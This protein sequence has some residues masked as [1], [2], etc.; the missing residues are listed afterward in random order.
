MGRAAFILAGALLLGGVASAESLGEWAGA[1][2]QRVDGPALPPDIATA[3]GQI[4]AQAANRPSAT[5]DWVI[6][7]TPQTAPKKRKKRRRR[8]RRRRATQ[9]RDV[10]VLATTSSAPPGKR[11]AK[12]GLL[13]LIRPTGGGAAIQAQRPVPLP[14]D[15]RWRWVTATDVDG[16]GHGDTILE[17][18]Q[19]SR[20]FTRRG[21]VVARTRPPALAMI[22][23]AS[24]TVTG[25]GKRVVEPKTAC[26]FP[27][28][29]L[30]SKALIVQRRETTTI[31]GVQRQIDA[32]ELF[33]PGGNGQLVD[34]HVYGAMYAGDGRER[35]VLR[36]WGKVFAV[37]RPEQALTQQGMPGDCPAAG[38][39]LPQ[40]ALG[41]SAS[42]HPMAIVGPFATS[43][44]G[45]RLALKAMG[46]R[47]PRAAVVIGIGSL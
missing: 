45:V 31:N 1:L 13:L 35:D 2:Q 36:R 22:E 40:R 23:L 44:S 9:P 4:A 37:R 33:V 17:W 14:A 11:G 28:R 26:F 16:D 47:A 29:G 39:V 38:V 12:S 41:Q 18:R 20:N 25:R 5:I 21:M 15:T 32:M 6:P 3:L 10:L 43:S 7:T 24:E 8:K 30:D 46:P 34:G 19:A 27:V 42:P